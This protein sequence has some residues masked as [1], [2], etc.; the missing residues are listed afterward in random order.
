MAF[1]ASQ[2][3][4][5]YARARTSSPLP[6]LPLEII[7]GFLGAGKSTL[8]NQL[9]KEPLLAETVVIVN[10]FGEIGIDHLLVES[11]DEG[12]LLLSS[13][14][15]CCSVRGDLVATLEDLLRRRD[16]GRIAPFKRVVIE[17][18]GLADPAPILHTLIHHPYLGLR[19]VLDGVIT[20]VDAVNG[21][22]TLDAHPEAIKQVAVADRLV[23]TK[24]DLAVD[25]VR[26]ESLRA[27][28]HGLNPGAPILNAADGEA[29][30]ARLLDAGLYD[31]DGKIADVRT[32]LRAEA[33]AD[34]LDHAHHHHAHH[35]SHH[36]H[37]HH[38]VNRHD[39]RIRA[40]CLSTP[41]AIGRGPFETFLDLLRSAHGPNLL[42]VKGIVKLAD[43]PERPVVVQGVQHLFHPT[44]TL[45]R[46]P[47]DDHTTRLVFILRDLDEIFVRR[48]WSAFIG[49]PVI[50]G[51]DAAALTDNPLALMR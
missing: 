48:L 31:A 1:P 3:N 33:F 41:Q 18:T 15:L 9:L 32:W 4:S 49:E 7:T 44:V 20:L 39:A 11:V 19:F 46:W 43:N 27:R 42:R 13:G 17:T 29:I 8:L 2:P 26:L 34:P 12:M 28:L 37:H 14:C 6:A 35:H 10:E 24:T 38:D 47:D 45:E 16:N 40:F 25:P 22:H 30:A 21:A 36:R 50:D 23:L 51:P 5:G